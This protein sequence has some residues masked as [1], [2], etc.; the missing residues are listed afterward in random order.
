M[1]LAAK[2]SGER[3]RI[4]RMMPLFAALIKGDPD[5]HTYYAELAFAYKDSESPD[6][7]QAMQYLD[8]AIALRGNQ[9]RAATWNYELSRAI[10]RIEAAHKREKQLRF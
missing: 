6:L 8:K 10:T 3:D 4:K 9:Q 5:Q 2:D 1:R 7:F